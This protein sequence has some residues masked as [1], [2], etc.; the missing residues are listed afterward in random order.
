MLELKDSSG[1]PLSEDEYLE[2]CLEAK[3]KSKEDVR[4]A[5]K[6]FFKTRTCKTLIRPSDDE[7]DI[8]NLKSD[9]K[10]IKPEFQ[11][12]VEQLKLFIFDNIGVKS[13]DGV[14]LSGPEFIR[15]LKSY[16]EA[17]NK[18]GIPTLTDTWTNVVET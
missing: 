17:I 4:K 18:G 1:S 12:Q 5:L 2:F 14:G 6:Q 3:Q 16:V 10:A 8:Q 15:M 13:L 7:R 9:L 11:K